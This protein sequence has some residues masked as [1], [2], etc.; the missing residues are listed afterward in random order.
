MLAG[1]VCTA[2]RVDQKHAHV[3]VY[4]NLLFDFVAE[5]CDIILTSK[6]EPEK[7]VRK[8]KNV[9]KPHN[10]I[11]LKTKLNT[12]LNKKLGVPKI[13]Q[14]RYELPKISKLGQ[15]INKSNQHVSYAFLI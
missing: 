1:G 6:T 3:P 11:K 2:S 8:T 5:C 13:T 7:K 9:F 4:V 14:H 12:D 15:H 10:R